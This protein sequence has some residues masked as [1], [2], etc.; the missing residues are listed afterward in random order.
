MGGIQCL[1]PFDA[2]KP[3][4]AMERMPSKKHRASIE[5]YGII[6]IEHYS[7]ARLQGLQTIKVVD[8]IGA[9]EMQ[10]KILPTPL[11]MV[12]LYAK[13]A[14][15]KKIPGWNGFMESVT[16]NQP[17]VKS[18][19]IVLPFINDPPTNYDTIFTS[20]HEKSLNCFF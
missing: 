20:L 8:V 16:C 14:Q 4:T 10:Q 12:W 9:L 13:W 7:K 1:S 2:I 15:N 17:Y 18:K 3:D 6:P 5:N 11:D 19:I